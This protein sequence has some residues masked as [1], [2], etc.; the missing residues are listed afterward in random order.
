MAKIITNGLGIELHGRAGH[1]VFVFNQHGLH[2]RPHVTPADPK[3]PA[4][5]AARARMAQASAAW[6]T[7]SPVNRAAWMNYARP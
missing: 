1:A 2:L 7:L 5:L 6:K 4:Q 3:T